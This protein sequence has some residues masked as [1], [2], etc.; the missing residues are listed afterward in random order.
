VTC[1]HPVL[2][3]AWAAS[4]DRFDYDQVAPVFHRLTGS[5]RDPLSRRWF[6]DVIA[7]ASPLTT[8]HSARV[9]LATE[10]WAA[11]VGV[12][13]IMAVGRWSSLAALMYVIGVLEDQVK[14]TDRVG[15]S[16]ALRYVDGDL[17]R[18]GFSPGQFAPAQAPCASATVWNGIVGRLA[19]SEE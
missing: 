10:L 19:P 8:P 4:E 6:A 2:M 3:E 14:A 17:R 13:D 12:D 1:A 18:A 16:G 5:T 15:T 11:G 9:G 7:K